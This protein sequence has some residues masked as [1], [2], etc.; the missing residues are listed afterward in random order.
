M[1]RL[2]N[3]SERRHFI[4]ATPTHQGADGNGTKIWLREGLRP[5]PFFLAPSFAVGQ[6][7]PYN[8][9]KDSQDQLLPQTASTGFMNITPSSGIQRCLVTS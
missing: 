3:Q 6:S 8:R 4:S 9:C 7:F 5:L 1:E 2:G